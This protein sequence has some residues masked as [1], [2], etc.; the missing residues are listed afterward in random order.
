MQGVRKAKMGSKERRQREREKRRDQ[1][2]DAARSLLFKKG[3][4]ATTVQDIAHLAELSPGTIYLYFESKEAIFAALNDEGLNL[5]T[6]KVVEAVKGSRPPEERLR[7]IAMAYL[8]FSRTHKKYF[9]IINYFIT[10]PDI[11]FP[12]EL[13]ERFDRHGT[14]ILAHVA[15]AIDDGIKSGEFIKVDARRH[16]LILWASLQGLLQFGKLKHTILKGEDL[17]DLSR[18]GVECI[19]SA[20][21]KNR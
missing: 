19:I 12:T 6:E 9:D 20:I 16:A 4:S 14:S 17:E 21:R 8:A 1:I 11:V 7:K 10:T 13:K 3:I 18:Y 2:L 5:L 15:A